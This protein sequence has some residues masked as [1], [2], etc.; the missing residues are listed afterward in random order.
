MEA[1]VILKILNSFPLWCWVRAYV[2]SPNY[3]DV[4]TLRYKEEG[5]G[6]L[7]PTPTLEIWD[8]IWKW[9]AIPLIRL[10]D[11]QG[12]AFSPYR[13][14]SYTR[15]N[16][17]FTISTVYQIYNICRIFAIHNIRC[18]QNLQFWYIQNLQYPTTLYSWRSLYPSCPP[19]E[20]NSKEIYVIFWWTRSVPC[21]QICIRTKFIKSTWEIH[22]QA[23]L[24]F[25]EISILVKTT[26]PTSL[27]SSSRC[28]VDHGVRVQWKRK[29]RIWEVSTGILF[30]ERGSEMNNSLFL[31]PK[32]LQ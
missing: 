29:S 1:L 11:T 12:V 22:L 26:R 23:H 9:V 19:C 3:L 13:N 15:N 20:L 25:W 17:I 32:W 27:Q 5:V 10:F 4:F 30:K 8:L 21:H 6:L 14:P 16:T 2:L 24:Q 31:F 28:D 7:Y 18:I